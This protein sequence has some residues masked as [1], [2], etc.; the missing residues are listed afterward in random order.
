MVLL[1]ALSQANW[2]IVMDAAALT[3]ASCSGHCATLFF[4]VVRVT[5][6]L[7][8]LPMFVGFVIESFNSTLPIVTA[9]YILHREQ[10][11]DELEPKAAHDH[12][13]HS[14]TSSLLAR[15]WSSPSVPH[16]P[17]AI[18]TTNLAH[19]MATPVGRSVRGTL[20]MFAGSDELTFPFAALHVVG[21]GGGSVTVGGGSAPSAGSVSVEGTVGAGSTAA[22]QLPRLFSSHSKGGHGSSMLSSQATSVLQPLLSL[23]EEATPG[24]S[25]DGDVDVDVDVADGDD[26]SVDLDAAETPLQQQGRYGHTHTHIHT[27]TLYL[28]LSLSLS[29]SPHVYML[30]RG[31]SATHLLVS[32]RSRSDSS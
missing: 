14:T 25:V 30:S 19:A 15:T 32:P 7:I 23:R 2:D 11:H 9:D 4:F 27:H 5:T 21:A 16:P 20:D 10:Q 6:G 18:D 22:R 8:F 28:S 29:L 12:S 26:D 1:C 31:C 24:D 17:L 3:T 13:L